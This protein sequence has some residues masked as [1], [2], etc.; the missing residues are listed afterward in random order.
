[1]Q[2]SFAITAATSL[3]GWYID[4][5]LVFLAANHLL[6][7]VLCVA[8]VPHLTHFPGVASESAGVLALKHLKQSEV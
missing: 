5:A 1:M 7:I 6:K 2:Q 8:G 4:R 3:C